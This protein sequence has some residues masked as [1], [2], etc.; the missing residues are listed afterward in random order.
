MILIIDNY[1]S[2][3]HN[4]ARYVRLCGFETLVVRHNDITVEECLSANAEGVVISPGPKGPDVAGVSMPLI[5][6]LPAHIPLFGVCLGH[7]C[8][9]QAFGGRVVRAQRPLHGSSS[10]VRHIETGLFEGVASPTEVGRYHS[11]IAVP[12]ED[13]D[14]LP[15]AWSEEGEVM[16]VEHRSRPLFGVQFHPE[17]L[18]TKDGLQIVSNFLKHCR[19]R[20]T[21]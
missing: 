5:D 2:F 6:A 18:L 14:I 10:P 21:S 11:L 4:L 12:S 3:V 20:E 13:G 9:V 1:D 7:Q 15:T 8:L 19:K 16:A 17:S